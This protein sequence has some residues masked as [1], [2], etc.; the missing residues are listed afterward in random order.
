[1]SHHGREYEREDTCGADCINT[2]TKLRAAVMLLGDIA[3]GAGTTLQ[4]V[5]DR[6]DVW[7]DGHNYDCPR[8]AGK[9]A[10]KRKAELD[11]QIAKLTEERAKL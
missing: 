7:L 2:A 6:C 4:E 5:R 9:Q 11:A 3:K 1:M 10:A 8:R